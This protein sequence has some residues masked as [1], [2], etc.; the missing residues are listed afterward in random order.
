MKTVHF[1]IL[2]SVAITLPLDLV[3]KK[4]GYLQGNLRP[5][6]HLTADS[7]QRFCEATKSYRLVK[8]LDVDHPDGPDFIMLT[9]TV[10][11][12]GSV[13][14][15]EHHMGYEFLAEYFHVTF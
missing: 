6:G 7:G 3:C 1:T 8:V 10:L 12:D 4:T 9:E 14:M 15:T 2:K 5:D 13:V 11:E